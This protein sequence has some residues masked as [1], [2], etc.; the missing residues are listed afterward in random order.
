MLENTPRKVSFVNGKFDLLHPGHLSLLKVAKSLGDFVIVC[1]DSDKRII[2]NTG[3]APMMDEITREFMVK[4]FLGDN[5]HVTVFETDE[6]LKNAIHRAWPIYVVKG[7]DYS[8]KDFFEKSFIQTKTDAFI[9]YVERTKHSSS[10]YK[11]SIS[12][13]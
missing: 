8:N 3:K 11:K 1:L 7:S 13:R 6:E 10:E 4:E 12:T 5:S 9:V 2:K